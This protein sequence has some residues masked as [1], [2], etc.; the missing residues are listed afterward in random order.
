MNCLCLN[1]S[2]KPLKAAWHMKNAS[3]KRSISPTVSVMSHKG[4]EESTSCLIREAK[5][6]IEKGSGFFSSVY[7]SRESTLV[8]FEDSVVSLFRLLASRLS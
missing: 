2:K 4:F 8:V 5:I 1:F 7:L 3:N 6:L